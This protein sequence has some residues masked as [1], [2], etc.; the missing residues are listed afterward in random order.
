MANSK[1]NQI[2]A[3]VSGRKTSTEKVTTEVYHK[4][5]KKDLLEG[6]SRTYRPLNEDDKELYPAEYKNVQYTVDE[7][8]SDFTGPLTELMNLVRTQD[9][10]NC[11]A[12]ADIEVDGRVLMKDVPVT[13]LLF[14]EKKIED[15]NTFFSKLPTL[16]PGEIWTFDSATAS[17][18]SKEAE[19]TKTKKI[20]KNHV[21]AAATDKHPAQVDTFTEDVVVGFWKKKTFSGAVPQ[22]RKNE[23]LSR[24]LKLKEAIKVAREEANNLDVSKSVDAANLFTFITE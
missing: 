10:G 12:K 13:H 17:W 19:T 5:Q 21:K 4:L 8:I 7:A 20:L 14:L 2:I 16:D 18:V 1:L 3:V 22:K 6:I 23:F 9:N 24:I 15:V 11:L